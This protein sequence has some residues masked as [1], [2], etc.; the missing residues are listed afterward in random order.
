MSCKGIV[1][2]VVL[3]ILLEANVIS[4]VTY[5]AMVIVAVLVTG[6]TKPLVTLVEPRENVTRKKEDIHQLVRT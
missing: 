5:A 1:E 4:D 6:L 3:K 2:I